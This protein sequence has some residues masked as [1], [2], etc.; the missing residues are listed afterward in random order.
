[1]I[2]ELGFESY[3]VFLQVDYGFEVGRKR[4]GCRIRG[5]G[6][7]VRHVGARPV[8]ILNFMFCSVDIY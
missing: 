2:L 1:M 3:I 4:R 5:E 7:P 6:S 8:K